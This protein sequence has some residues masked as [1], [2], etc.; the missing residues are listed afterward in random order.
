MENVESGANL[1][2]LAKKRTLDENGLFQDLF[3]VEKKVGK[4]PTYSLYNA[5]GKY[6]IR[7]F[8]VRYGK[9]SNVI[10]FYRKWKTENAI[11]C[12]EPE[13]EEKPILKEQKTISK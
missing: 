1:L 2:D 12:S 10:S 6:S 3:L 8:R 7:P 9:W 4:K 5:N 13:T 11:S